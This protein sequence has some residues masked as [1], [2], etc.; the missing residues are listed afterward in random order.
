MT[1]SE[2]AEQGNQRTTA[3]VDR[4]VLRTHRRLAEA[5]IALTVERG[6]DDVTIRDITERA[7]VGYATYFRHYP[8]KDALLLDVLDVFLEEL[9][10]LL[11]LHAND[12]RPE[13]SSELVFDFARE[14]SQLCRVL[15]S[16]RTSPA[17]IERMRQ[18]GA[19][20]ALQQNAPLD[21]SF[22]PA[23]VAAHHMVSASI[24]LIQW[25][26]D[27]DMPYSPEHMARIHFELIVRP[28]HTL[29]FRA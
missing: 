12:E 3:R 20:S 24:A 17:L 26:L 14:H 6:Y 10:E 22:V 8:D 28:T 15:L 7:E 1:R 9:L 25:W 29:A 19:Q 13:R 23:E 27:R 11:Q 18:V 21:D 2:K 16:S 4:R 5:L